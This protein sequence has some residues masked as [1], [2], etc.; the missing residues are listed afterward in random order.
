VRRLLCNLSL[1][2]RVVVT[3]FKACRCML[4]IDAV[5]SSLYFVMCYCKA[6]F[7]LLA[8]IVVVL[9]HSSLG[10]A[11]KSDL[12]PCSRGLGLRIRLGLSGLGCNCGCDCSVY[13]RG[14]C[15]TWKQPCMSLNAI[16]HRSCF[17]EQNYLR[18]TPTESHLSRVGIICPAHWRVESP[19]GVNWD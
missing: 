15:V 16:R 10:L 1:M 8:Y 9:S 13:P 5:M 14:L 7:V 11:L 18:E 2:F 19:S 12:R 6:R 4:L 17:L 3:I